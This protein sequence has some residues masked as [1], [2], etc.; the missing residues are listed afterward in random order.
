MNRVMVRTDHA[1]YIT[2]MPRS[3]RGRLW[4][5]LAIAA[6]L[7]AAVYQLHSQGRL[8]WCSCG[9]LYLWS[10]NVWGSHNSQHF[11]DPYSFTHILHGLIF[12]GLLAWGLPR[13]AP[14]WRLWLAISIEA[15]WE[16]FENTDFVIQRYRQ[17]TVALN[18]QGDTIFNSLGDILMC[19]IGFMLAR[20]LG[21][22]RSLVLFAVTEV[23][24]LLWARDS[25]VLNV[26]MLLC[27]V[28]AIK[29]WQMGR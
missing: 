3:T 17:A 4:A 15:A 6:V 19:G 20:Y 2:V 26:L 1:S 11:L 13:L 24:L 8:W 23:V 27:P 18:Y 16:V 22:R 21:F 25:L 14:M 9:R 7:A 12:C 10:G 5:W 29:A 28:D